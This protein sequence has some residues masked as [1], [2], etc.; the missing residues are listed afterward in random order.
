MHICK[1]FTCE[2]L[3]IFNVISNHFTRFFFVFFNKF[4]SS[5]LQVFLILRQFF[6]KFIKHDILSCSTW[7]GFYKQTFTENSLLI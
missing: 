5:D 6:F 7:T 2:F 3:T 1:N 4:C